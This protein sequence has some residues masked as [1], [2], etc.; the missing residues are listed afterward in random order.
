MIIVDCNLIVLQFNMR[1]KIF[2]ILLIFINSIHAQNISINEDTKKISILE[3]TTMYIDESS[4]MPFEE[5]RKQKFQST[6][7]DYIRLGY[8]SSTAWVKFTIE[9]HSNKK[10]ERYITITNNM[11]DILELYIKNK[12]ESYTLSRQ[13]LLNQDYFDKNNLLHSNFKIEFHPNETKEFYYKAH[14]ISSANFFQL[15]L[16][17]KINLYKDEFNYQLIIT[18]FIGAMFALIIYNLFIYYFTKEISYLWYVFYIFFVTWNHI[19]YSN[20][21]SYFIKKEYAN[22]ELFAAVY[23]ISIINIFAILFLRYILNTQQYKT[24][25]LILSSF[26]YVNVILIIYSF[27]D[28]NI[29]EY[30]SLT[31]FITMLYLLFICFYSYI[32]DNEQSKYIIIGWSINIVGIVMLYLEN[33]FTWSLIDYFPYFYEW[34]VFTE[35]ILFSIALASKL[36]KTKELEISLATNEVLTKELHHRVKNNMQFII[37]LYRTKL[38]KL[39]LTSIKEELKNIEG[40]I[41]AM[42]KTHEMLYSKND[43]Y[44]LDTQSYF[45][46]LINII[47][48]GFSQN[49]IIITT[50]IESSVDF[51][52]LIYC[53]IILNELM[54]NS[55]KYAFPNH[56]GNITVS[57][58]SKNNSNYLIYEDDGI[59]FDSKKQNN[60]MGLFL[61]KSLV[62]KELKGNLTID[63]NNK[64][65][66]IIEF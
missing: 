64:A 1:E 33:A 59:G 11:H 8:T 2:I 40:S 63:S 50:K 51:D 54:T 20:M 12:D 17:D 5:I 62:K 32:K 57:M 45:D 23:Y 37:S 34:T 46:D 26:I 24:I 29:I 66:F 42:S 52:N 25:N 4:S 55:F 53:G 65:K 13:G 35:A 56:Q 58:Y 60:Y 48:K 21:S 27:I 3:Y 16:K 43:L 39:N 47:K 36:N 22:I 41:Q 18:L 38:S 10:L 15:Y 44:N 19:S 14:S 31:V 6:N 28:I 9:N 30:I 49:S 61:I 7:T